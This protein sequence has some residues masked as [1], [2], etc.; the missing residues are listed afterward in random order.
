MTVYNVLRYN[1]YRFRLINAASN[2]C[3]LILKIENHNLTI[4][5][6]DGSS[7]EPMTVETLSSTSGER[8]DFV[9][10]MN[11]EPRD[12][13]IQTKGFGLCNRFTGIAVLRYGSK[14]SA[15]KTSA[16]F[17][18]MES[19]IQPDPE[20]TEKTF[21]NP[22][23]NISGIHV[24][25]AQSIIVDESLQSAKPDHEF[26]LFFGTPHVNRTDLFD[27]PNSIKYMGENLRLSFTFHLLKMFI[28]FSFCI[29]RTR[30]D[31]DKYRS[32]KQYQS[33]DA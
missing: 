30:Q 16:D 13:S 21:N 27:K 11:K 33:C 7:I 29:T 8:Y 2:V 25:E 12:Y 24:S 19:F 15:G 28:L 17:I 20:M 6:V 22:L 4:I 5:A 10:E 31:F 3:T 26:N 9:V 18:E 1:R 14:K 32:G 23:F